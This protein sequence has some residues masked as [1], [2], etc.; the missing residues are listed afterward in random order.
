[1]ADVPFAASNK[2]LWRGS[3]LSGARDGRPALFRA[4]QERYR[5]DKLA[6]L[7]METKLTSTA[8]I[9]TVHAGK[10][11]VQL[12]KHW[13]HRFPDLT[14]NETRADI[15][16]PTGQC[17]ITSNENILAIALTVPDEETASRMEDVV[18]EHLKRFAFRES[19]E[20]IWQRA[21]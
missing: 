10:Y 6:Q 12:A 5:R 17:V 9:E 19:L 2:K 20:I 7:A 11:L 3:G 15:P 16:F 18:E 21:Q 13:S 8:K 4:S 1:M 14:W